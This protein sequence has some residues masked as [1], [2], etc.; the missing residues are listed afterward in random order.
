MVKRKKGPPPLWALRL[1]EF[2][3]QLGLSQE[4]FGKM[5]GLKSQQAWANYEKGREP[6]FEVLIALNTAWGV[7]LDDLI[8]GLR[9]LA[10]LATPNPPTNQVMPLASQIT[11]AGRQRYVAAVAKVNESRP[12]GPGH[13][14]QQ[15]M[16]PQGRQGGPKGPKK[17]AV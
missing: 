12:G 3:E 16:P 14:I 2:R 7:S 15:L 8:L 4:D 17:P 11:G 10:S 5:L 9:Q 1:K 6:P 13:G